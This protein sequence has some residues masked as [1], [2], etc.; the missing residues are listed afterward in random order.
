MTG[1]IEPYRADHVGSLL[2]PSQVLAAHK[3]YEQGAMGLEELREIEDA[4]VTGALALQREAGVDVFT[5][6]EYRRSS[7]LSGPA[8]WLEGFAPPAE[9]FMRQWH[10]P[11]GGLVP[12]R[13]QVVAGKLTPKGRFTAHETA[14]MKEHSPG[15]IKVTMPSPSMLGYGGFKDGVTDRTYGT[16][17]EMLQDLARLINN[18]L[19]AVVDEGIPY[20]QL[21][22]P[23]YATRFF[24]EGRRR[25]LQAQGVDV[26]A[27]LEEFL[28]ADN[29]CL[30]GVKGHG[31]TV[32]V[33]LCRGN[34][35]SRWQTEGAYDPIAE[36]LFGSLQVDRYLLEY[37]TPRSGSFRPLRFVPPGKMVVLGLITTKDGTLES[38]DSLLKRVDEASEYVPLENLAISPQCGFASI[39][40]GNLLSW[41]DQRRKL[42]SV[43]QVARRIWG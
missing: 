6:G 20:V 36:K 35:R 32:A 31:V 3:R 18:E 4:A 8:Q 14:Y 25:E 7:F 29:A 10:G 37:D 19:R 30:R 16:R 33:H 9:S 17:S 23:S 42:E 43:A 13:V 28:A 39:S 26:E 27:E 5:D 22:A 12:T 38:Q 1:M 41:D 21:D 15:P 11:G 40:T 34:H 2:R 24:G